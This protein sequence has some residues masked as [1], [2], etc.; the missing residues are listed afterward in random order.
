MPEV[1]PETEALREV[2]GRARIAGFLGPGR[3]EGH[4]GH[5]EGF[6]EAAETALG[7]VPPNFAD[8][9]TGGGIPELVLAVRL[10]GSRGILVDSN[11][12]RCSALREAGV[13]GGLEARI[14]VLQQREEEVARSSEYRVQ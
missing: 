9:G 1:S 10:P 2:L 8:L 13:R 12:P 5:A 14:G 3:V 7:R 6:A 4:L 11:Q